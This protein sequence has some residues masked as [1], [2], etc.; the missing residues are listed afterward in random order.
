M[1]I[2]DFHAY[3]ACFNRRDYDGVLKFWADDFTVSFA[4]YDFRGPREFI[5]FYRFFHKHV[6]ET[7]AIDEFLSNDRMVVLEARVRLEGLVDISA[8][9]LQ[10]AG[11]GRLMTPRVGQVVEIPQFIHYHLQGGKFS[12]VVC[13]V[14][15]EP[16]FLS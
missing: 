15:A 2:A 14:A 8:N 5:G 1:D 12:R 4:G 6:N 9:D 16:G 3:L 10:A 7:I 11:Y 13:A